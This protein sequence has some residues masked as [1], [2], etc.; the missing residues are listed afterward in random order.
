MYN[1]DYI[2]NYVYVRDKQNNINRVSYSG[3]QIKMKH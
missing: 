1:V 3:S 2:Y